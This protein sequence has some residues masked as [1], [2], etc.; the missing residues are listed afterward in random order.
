[1][2]TR[3][4][5]F[6]TKFKQFLA[7]QLDQR[8]IQIGTSTIQNPKMQGTSVE[9]KAKQMDRET[10]QDSGPLNGMPDVT[11]RVNNLAKLPDGKYTIKSTD[12]IELPRFADETRYGDDE[13]QEMQNSID[14]IKDR[15]YFRFSL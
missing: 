5:L 14:T 13:Q 9:F 11:V 3:K 15:L 1:M 10:Y 4:Y 2:E 6:E 12:D 7:E 8:T